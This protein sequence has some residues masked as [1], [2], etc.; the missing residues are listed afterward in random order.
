[1]NNKRLSN[2]ELLRILCIVLILSMHS[3]ALVE[4]STLNSLNIVLLHMVSAVG[5]IGVSCFVLISGYFGIKFRMYRFVQ[6]VILTT[7]YTVLVHLF[8]NGIT[9]DAGL[10][11]SILVVPLYNNWFI[12][13]YLLLML[14]SPFLNLLAQQMSTHQFLNCLIVGFLAFSVLPTGLNTP[15]Y[16]VVT[17]GGKCLIYMIYLYMVGRFLRLHADSYF[18]RKKT[19]GVFALLQMLIILGN[20]VVEI[21]AHKPCRILSLDCSPLILGSAV[22]AFYYFKSLH[23]HSQ[24]IN[25][26][27]VSILAVYLLDGMRIWV[28]KLIQIHLHA[29]D[30]FLFV[31]LF[32]L[33]SAT[34]CIAI[35][36]DNIRI[37]L[38][39]KLESKTIGIIAD[40]LTKG[41]KYVEN[42][43]KNLHNEY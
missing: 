42:K 36:I 8:L 33:V 20:I 3:I 13:C 29:N 17:G 41:Q 5:N 10:I 21:I 23:F 18:D 11:K 25:R 34:F 27:S 31:Y 16:T 35:I 37:I 14:F 15:W 9:I 4:T 24:I 28:N 6:L 32:A 39:G 1:M 7:F 19:F 26:I 30:A 40:G 43:I 2:I 22:C 38:L 12:A